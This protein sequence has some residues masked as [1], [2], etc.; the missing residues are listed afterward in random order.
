[1]SKDNWIDVEDYLPKKGEL[2]KCKLSKDIGFGITQ[3]VLYRMK[4]NGK[5]ND[6]HDLVTHWRPLNPQP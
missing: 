6:Y 4:H 5:W 1:M 2:V 3:K